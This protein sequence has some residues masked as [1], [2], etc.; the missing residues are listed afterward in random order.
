[1]SGRPKSCFDRFGRPL[2]RL[3]ADGEYDPYNPLHMVPNWDGEV[4][5]L[6]FNGFISTSSSVMSPDG[7]R[8]QVSTD[9]TLTVADPNVDIRRGDRIKDGSHIYT[10]DVIPSVDANPF[11]GWQPTLEVGLQEVEG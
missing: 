9:A 11:T 7:A 10:V 2:K 6:A 1:M 8:E 4:D 5:E 3:R